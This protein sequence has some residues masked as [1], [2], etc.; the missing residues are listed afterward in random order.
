MPRKADA[1]DAVKISSRGQSLEMGDVVE[2]PKR[3]RKPKQQNAEVETP[4]ETVVQAEPVV[5]DAPVAMPVDPPQPL[6][7]EAYVVVKTCKV[8][9]NGAMVTLN[10]GKKITDKTFG[11]GSLSKLKSRGIELKLIE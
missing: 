11:P 10:E 6:I 2:I 5:I 3:G 7:A 8:W 1:L 4:K 9:I